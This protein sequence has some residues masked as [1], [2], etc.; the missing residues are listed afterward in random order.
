MRRARGSLRVLVVVAA[1][2]AA[3]TAPFV[4]ISAQAQLLPPPPPIDPTWG[5]LGGF[6][7]PGV[8]FPGYSPLPLGGLGVPWAAPSMMPSPSMPSSTRSRSTITIQDF[9]FSPAELTVPVGTTVTWV[10]RGGTAHTAT[11]PGVWDSGRVAPGRSFSAIFAVT[12]TFDYACSIHPDMKGRIIVQPAAESPSRAVGTGPAALLQQMTEAV[13]RGDAAAAMALFADDATLTGAGPCMMTACTG[14]DAV[15]R[16]LQRQTASHLRVQP[17]SGQLQTSGNSVTAPFQVTADDIR[18]LGVERLVGQVTLEARDG[19]IA[20]L[21]IQLDPNDPQSA[22][23]MQR[24]MAAGG[25]GAPSAPASAQAAAGA[26]TT[27]P[28]APAAPAAPAAGAQMAMADLAASNNSG[29]TGH[30]ML[31]QAGNTTTVQVTLSGMAPGSA[32]AGHIHS[33]ACSGPIIFP[34]GTI[35]A[36]SA[37]QGSATATVNA[38]IDLSTW[39]VQYHASDSPPGPPIACGQPTTGGM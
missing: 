39:W 33:G 16:E 2:L 21:R 8:P 1:A 22:Q 19:K 13:N 28:S 20:A 35:T 18:A 9:S 27:A 38:P 30:A 7:T 37:G 36:D 11:D 4:A 24:M 23:V 17:G 29:V 34:L 14:R 26:A 12:G 31:T 25:T 10:N 3:L 5:A 6:A 32:H 15:Q